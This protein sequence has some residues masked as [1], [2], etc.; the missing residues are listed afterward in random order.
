MWTPLGVLCSW[1]RVSLIC[2]NNCP[3]RCNTKQS[4]YYYATSL[5]MFW[6]ST[7]PIIRSTQNCNYSLRYCAATFVRRDQAWP[8]W[9]EV[10]AQKIWPVQEAVVTVLCTPDDGC[11]WHPKHVE[12]TRII[13][14]R[15]LCVASRWA[16]INIVLG[17]YRRSVLP[18]SFQTSGFWKCGEGTKDGLL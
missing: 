16:I 1:F 17:G 18:M 13:I 3:T 10:A 2:I 4:I 14:N 6:V 8:R 11:G 5:Y 9:R 15:L 7:T 12:W